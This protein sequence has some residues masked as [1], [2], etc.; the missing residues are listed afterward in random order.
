MILAQVQQESDYL[1]MQWP[2]DEPSGSSFVRD[3][4]NGLALIP[5]GSPVLG[6]NPMVRGDISTSMLGGYGSNG[7]GGFTPWYFGG[8]VATTSATAV[9]LEAVTASEPNGRS[10]TA[11]LDASNSI[12]VSGSSVVAK[13]AGVS[14]T[15]TGVLVGLPQLV[16]VTA[17]KEDGNF[18]IFVDGNVAAASSQAWSSGFSIGGTTSIGN[19][20]GYSSGYP[21]TISRVQ[22]VAVYE[23][24]LSANDVLRH[25][26]A[27]MQYLD[28]PGHVRSYTKPG[29]ST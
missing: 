21:L 20:F 23:G 9:T 27:F 29:A 24:C 17:S 19:G 16:T 13:L 7:S 28:D 25:A 2:L 3:L 12:E 8:S 18:T 15:A 10:F 14:L 22:D 4:I 6:E 1:L 5:T 26:Q 11:Y